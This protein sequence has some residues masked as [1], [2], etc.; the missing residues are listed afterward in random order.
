VGHAPIRDSHQVYRVG[1]SAGV[2]MS[3]DSETITATLARAD[4]A[5]LGA[6][7]SGKDRTLSLAFS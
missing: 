3:V 5:L 7:A 6:K 2:A 4:K 1:A